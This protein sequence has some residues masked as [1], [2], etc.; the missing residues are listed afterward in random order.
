M[1]R[2]LALTLL[3]SSVGH[4]HEPE[5]ERRVLVSIE[6]ARLQLVVR[7]TLKPSATSERLFGAFDANHDGRV[8]LPTEQ[9]ARAQLLVP[10]AREG[11]TLLVDDVQTALT[12][13]EVKFRD[14][15]GG[16]RRG[17]ETLLLLEAPLDGAAP[18]RVTLKVFRM[19]TTV[20]A[21]VSGLRRVGTSLPVRPED[22]VVG[23]ATLADGDVWVEVAPAK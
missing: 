11:L 3:L 4:A 8:S 23:P 6:A 20:E 13:V 16:K 18:H 14:L 7:Y 17:V 2:A 19:P 9:L 10:R 12:V 5:P 1:T 21:Q 15:T 22:P